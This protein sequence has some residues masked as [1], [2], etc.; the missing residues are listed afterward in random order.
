MLYKDLLVELRSKE[1]LNGMLLFSLVVAVIFGFIFEP[2]SEEL[3][4]AG[5]GILWILLVFSGNIGLARSFNR[6]YE[7]AMMQGLL[8]CPIDRS[9]IFPAKWIGNMIF[10][11]FELLILIP[12]LVILF[13]LP[14]GEHRLSLAAVLLLGVAGYSAVGTL[15][16]TIAAHCRAREVMLPLLLFPV[17]VPI[18]LAGVK[19]S[20]LMMTDAGLKEAV[21]WVKIL[22]AVD[23]IFIT[24]SFLL[25]EHIVEE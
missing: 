5:P 6:E 7:N 1:I 13:D 20:A 24:A 22:A 19:A 9:V 11:S 17:T 25:Y 10:I 12:L 2:G 18:L 16:S 3:K 15:F 4:T 23:V 8:L 21:S 14:L